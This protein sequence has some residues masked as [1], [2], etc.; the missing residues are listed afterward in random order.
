[1][2]MPNNLLLGATRW[3]LWLMLALVALG[4]LA[5]IGISIAMIFAWPEVAAEIQNGETLMNPGLIRPQLAML[6]ALFAV[7]LVGGAY[8]IRNLQALVA[9]AAGDPFTLANASR[10]RA[11]GW[12]MVGFQILAVPIHMAASSIAAA[13]VGKID[14]GGI[15]LGGILAILLAFILAAIFERGAAM[16]EELEGTV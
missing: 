15:S 16:R 8:I 5:V 13:G 4:A 2:S 1:M 10:L 14:A 3:L 11:I 9:S 12:T 7:V 6:L